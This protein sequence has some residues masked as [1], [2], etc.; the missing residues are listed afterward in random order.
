MDTNGTIIWQTWW[1][2]PEDEMAYGIWANEFYVYIS[3]S[4]NSWEPVSDKMVLIKWSYSGI[5]VDSSWP[6]WGDDRQYIPQSIFGW[7]YNIYVCGQHN[8]TQDTPDDYIQFLID[9][10]FDQ[11]T[12]IETVVNSQG[13]IFDANCQVTGNRSNF[14]EEWNGNWVQVVKIYEDSWV[15]EGYIDLNELGKKSIKT[16][17]RWGF[18]F[19]RRQNHLMSNANW[20][21][22]FYYYDPESFGVIEFL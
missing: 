16:G 7:D 9:S 11:E 5:Y 14:D 15:L 20:N 10:N 8:V 19:K 12:Y 4:T 18:N 3:A 6:W 22:P 1:D 13:V 17:E 21:V 2:G